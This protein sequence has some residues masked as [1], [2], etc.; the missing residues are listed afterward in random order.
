MPLAGFQI[1]KW[2]LVLGNKCQ[3]C[4]GSIA[5]STPVKPGYGFVGFIKQEID[6]TLN[7]LACHAG[8][9]NLYP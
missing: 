6:S 5:D 7:P 4:L 2:F 8:A 9:S 3:Y 1:G